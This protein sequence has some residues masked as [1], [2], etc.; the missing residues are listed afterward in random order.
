MDDSERA[1]LSDALIDNGLH[2]NGCMTQ[3]RSHNWLFV[4]SDNRKTYMCKYARKHLFESHMC[5]MLEEERVKHRL[6]P[7]ELLNL[8]FFQP[9]LQRY[10]SIIVRPLYGANFHAVSTEHEL[11]E[12]ALL[13]LLESVKGLLG[14]LQERNVCIKYISPLN[15]VFKHRGLSK[16]IEFCAALMAEEYVHVDLDSFSHEIKTESRSWAGRRADELKKLQVQD[17]NDSL[18]YFVCFMAVGELPWLKS[19]KHPD[20]QMRTKLK[21]AFKPSAHL[22]AFRGEQRFKKLG[23]L[24][25][26]IYSPPHT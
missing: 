19:R 22:S 2:W 4:V 20:P 3:E 24:L 25:D 11:S 15:F 26:K 1:L 13:C 14:Y 9:T 23:A 5:S 17:D 16:C 12:E 8:I 7:K 10:V 6:L 18:V 21:R